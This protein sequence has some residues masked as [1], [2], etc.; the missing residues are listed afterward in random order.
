[1]I[2]HFGK[3]LGYSVNVVF[4]IDNAYYLW[5]VSKKIAPFWNEEE[6]KPRIVDRRR[7]LASNSINDPTDH[8][9][10]DMMNGGCC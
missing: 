8:Y 3:Y 1:M 9:Y 2:I 5:A 10:S 6:D 7:T 4:L